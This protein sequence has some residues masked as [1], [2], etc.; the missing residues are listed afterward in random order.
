MKASILI[1]LVVLSLFAFALTGCQTT[2]SGE[3]QGMT[4]NKPVGWEMTP[5]GVYAPRYSPAQ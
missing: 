1:L 4:S 5:A 2:T 3:Q